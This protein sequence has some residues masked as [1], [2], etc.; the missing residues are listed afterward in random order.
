MFRQNKQQNVLLS[1]NLSDITP[2]WNTVKRVFF[3]RIFYSRFS[4]FESHSRK[5]R[6]REIFHLDLLPFSFLLACFW[7]IFCYFF[8]S[9]VIT[10]FCLFAKNTCSRKFWLA[11]REHQMRA[12]TARFTVSNIS[13]LAWLM[14]ACNVSVR[15]KK[16]TRHESHN[17][18]A[19]I[20]IASRPDQ[21][22]ALIIQRME[23]RYCLFEMNRIS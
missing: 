16:K 7:A 19:M 4:R 8:V 12:K 18:N 21:Q 9:T 5:I 2:K 15:R 10:C 17:A 22:Q 11:I 13:F 14:H 6:N 1:P 20:F 3:A 23:S